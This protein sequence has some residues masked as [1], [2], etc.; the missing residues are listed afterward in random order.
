V[1]RRVLVVA[2]SSSPS[3]EGVGQVRGGLHRHALAAACTRPI[4]LSQVTRLEG[5]AEGGLSRIE[6]PDPSHVDGGI[7]RTAD[8]RCAERLSIPA[9]HSLSA[10]WAD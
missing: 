4:P 3:I 2:C 7:K 1:R 8:A 9:G 10:R 6:E 5:L